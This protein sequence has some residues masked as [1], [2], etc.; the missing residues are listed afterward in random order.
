MTIRAVAT[1]SIDVT[2]T[3]TSTDSPASPVD[4]VSNVRRF[5]AYNQVNQVLDVNTTPK[6]DTVVD[7]SHT[8]SGTSKTWDLTAAPTA[9]NITDTVD[10]TGKKL[11]GLIAYA[12]PDNNASG[13]LIKSGATNGYDLF[14]N[15][16]YGVVL[17]PGMSLDLFQLG[18]AA[19]EPAVGASD[20]TID[21]TGTA[22]DVVQILAVFGTQ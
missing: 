9:K 3:T 6:A 8:F 10:L 17:Y 21:L 1:A 19:G 13:V 7:L 18:A 22:A 14:G 11:V 15:A 12:D 2:E 16:A 4:G 20:K 5:N